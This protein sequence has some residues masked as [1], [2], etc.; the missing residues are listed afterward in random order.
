MEGLA[1][2]S[3][4]AGIISLG[5]E[6]CQGLLRY[7]NSYKGAATDVAH[8]YESIDSLESTLLALK[9]T[10]DRGSLSSSVAAN[11]TKSIKSCE[12]GFRKLEEKLK[13]VKLSSNSQVGWQERAKGQLKRA[14][15]PFRESTLAKLREIVNEQR[16]HLKLAL[17]VLQ[18]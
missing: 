7:Y 13:K 12:A 1:S 6:V 9:R 16:D 14:L 10:L 11:V 4:V 18:M 15:Y 17:G 8:M 3:A 2:A 5:I